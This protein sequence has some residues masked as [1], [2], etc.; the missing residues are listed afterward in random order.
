MTRLEV[1]MDDY[2]TVLHESDRRSLRNKRH[3]EQVLRKKLAMAIIGTVLVIVMSVTLGSLLV[4]AE[5]TDTAR[6]YKYYT[7]IEVKYG[8]TLWSIAE[9]YS[10]PAHYASIEDYIREVKKINSLKDDELIIAG[11]YIVVPY[12]AET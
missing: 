8:E 5:G 9:E 6:S 3:R 12:Y 11:R 10:D 4:S 7:S 2:L 1:E